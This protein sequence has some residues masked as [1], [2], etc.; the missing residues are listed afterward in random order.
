LVC[1][2]KKNLATLL[3]R[4]NF[5]KKKGKTNIFNKNT[6]VIIQI[7]TSVLPRLALKSI[8]ESAVK[9]VLYLW[10]YKTLKLTLLLKSSMNKF[11][12]EK[13]IKCIEYV[14]ISFDTFITF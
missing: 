10:T 6:V 5:D 4:A 11:R 7:Q 8:L 1:C 14:R 3:P 12:N 9:D 2:T 13:Q